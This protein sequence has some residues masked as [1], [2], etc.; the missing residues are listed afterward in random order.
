MS[1]NLPN[2]GSVLRCWMARRIA[3]LDML[4][5]G[6]GRRYGIIRV[7]FEASSVSLNVMTAETEHRISQI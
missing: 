5:E 7:A 3:N 4:W 2:V 1:W 6:M